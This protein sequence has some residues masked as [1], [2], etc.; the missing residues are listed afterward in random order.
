MVFAI[1]SLTATGPLVRLPS[2]FNAT[3][4]NKILKKYIVHRLRPAIN[5]TAVF[6]QDNALF[7]AAKFFKTFLSE[8]DVTV[9]EWPAQSPDMN[10]V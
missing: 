1:I 6:M 2:K 3:V 9:M 4:H 8:E 10:P 7:H 5:Q